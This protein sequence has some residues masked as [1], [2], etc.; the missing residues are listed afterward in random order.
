[1]MAEFFLS[2][3]HHAPRREGAK[4]TKIPVAAFKFFSPENWQN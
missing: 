3:H 1:M 4:L 2:H